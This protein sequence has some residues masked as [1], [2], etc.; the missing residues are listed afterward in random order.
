MAML[1]T[2]RAFLS[3]ALIGALVACGSGTPPTPR[4]A[5]SVAV[6][7]YL[8]AASLDVL[9]FLPVQTADP[10]TGVI[11]T[12]FGTPP[13]S[14]RAY[15]ATVQVKDPAMDARSLNVSLLTRNGPVAVETE[16]AVTDA[17]LARARQ[18][19]IADGAL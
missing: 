19:R 12:G 11:T 9:S 5:E 15:R 8:W 4:G 18:L 13:G 1:L 10:F 6:N 2:K 16:R 17:I 3:V 14:G 7:R